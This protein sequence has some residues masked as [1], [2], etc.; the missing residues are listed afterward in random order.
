MATCRICYEPVDLI[1]VCKCDGTLKFVH[2]DC[3][4]KW[5]DISKRKT[6]EL[7]NAHYKIKISDPKKYDIVF[8]AIVYAS[9]TALVMLIW[10][11]IL[12]IRGL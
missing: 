12:S 6:C 10:A 1:T 2:R 8:P 4:V 7:C 9:I 5:I 3:I 11:I